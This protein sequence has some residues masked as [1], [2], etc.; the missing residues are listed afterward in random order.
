M[1][2]P[3]E[4]QKAIIAEAAKPRRSIMVEAGAGCAKST[5]LEM[6]AQGIKI[7]GLALTFA[8]ANTKVMK[9]KLPANF[10]ARSFN[11][12]GHTAW[13]RG[14]GLAYAQVKLDDRKISKLVTSVAKEWRQELPGDMWDLVRSL[15]TKA[16]Q[17]GLVPDTDPM[18]GNS[19]IPDTAQEW[20]NLAIDLGMSEDEAKGNWELARRVLIQSIALARQGIIS[21]D[22]QIYCSVLLGGKFPQFPVVIVD[23]DQDLNGLNIAMLAKCVRP[24][25]RIIAVGDKRQGIYG[26]RGALGD[27]AETIR[28][29]CPEWIDLPLMTTFRCPRAIVARQQSHVPGFR[30]WHGAA[31]GQVVNWRKPP[32]PPGLEEWEGWSWEQIIQIAPGDNASMVVLCRN[33]APLLSMAFKLLRKGIGCQMLGRDIGKGLVAL[34]RRLAP[35]DETPADAFRHAIVEWRESE[36]S[37][38][39]ANGRP[40]RV[41][42]ISDRA[43]CLLAVLDSGQAKDAGQCRV[44]LERL[45]ARQDGLI[46]LSSVH[47]AKGLEW[48]L[49]IHLDPWRVP[50]RQ[51]IKAAKAGDE[52]LLEQE[53]NL[54]YV[55]ETRSRHTLV[56]ASLDDFN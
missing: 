46:T 19:L 23:E 53:K 31:E 5:T 16:M 44:F 50:S 51:A 47:K 4:E 17:A 11:S 6:A 30:A 43:E 24:D 56:M 33:N 20:I 14:Q 55:C 10:D 34:S 29:I 27:A 3:T 26:F 22:D 21:F 28:T 2:S 1:F 40:E 18:G 52:G 39:V 37:K 7:P 45:F 35:D 32:G 42:G 48:D 36:E 9:E 41:A 38:S 15:V 13:M 49:V 54:K 25:G 12:M 8:K